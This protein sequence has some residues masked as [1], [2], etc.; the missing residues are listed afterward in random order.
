MSAELRTALQSA[1][2]RS[3]IS[4]ERCSK[5]SNVCVRVY[6]EN[7]KFKEIDRGQYLHSYVDEECRRG[8]DVNE[9]S[10]CFYVHL[11]EA[12]GINP[13]CLAVAMRHLVKT[14]LTDTLDGNV[15]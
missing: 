11:G 8:A 3:V 6:Q 15:I 1:C 4:N 5:I 2:G 13:F 14:L 7:F 10:R 12:M 9:G